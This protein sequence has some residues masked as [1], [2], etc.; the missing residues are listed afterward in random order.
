MSG[1][2]VGLDI[3]G[4]K[5]LAA[6]AGASGTI[7][8]RVSRRTPLSREEGVNTLHEMIEEVL[9]GEPPLA[10]GASAGGP[11]DYQ[12]GIVSPLHQP[13]WQQVPLRAIIEERWGAPLTVDVD[14]NVAVLGEYRYGGEPKLPLLY[15]TW[16]TGFGGALLTEQG[17]HRGVSD[18]HSEPGHTFV[19][20]GVQ[21]ACGA[22]GCLEALVSGSGIRRLYGRPP[23]QLGENEWQQ[24][25]AD[26]AVGLRNFAIL[27]APAVMVFGGGIAVARPDVIEVAAEAM[28]RQV[29]IVPA[30]DVR[31][32]RLGYDTALLGAVS[33][34]IHGL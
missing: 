31:L 21:C 29:H 11:L 10:I 33:I 22:E 14:T 24:V 1:R 20:S 2:Y 34:A 8:R 25:T 6:S 32:S 17:I 27:Y 9:D 19:R 28:R 13:E 16:S 23:E 18:A 30:P 3:G 5:M 12:T 4:T 26:L 7:L 15:L